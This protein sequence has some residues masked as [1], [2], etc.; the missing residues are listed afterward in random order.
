MIFTSVALTAI[1]AAANPALGHEATLDHGGTSYQVSYE[2]LVQ[3]RTKTVG[4][5]MGTRPSTER[6]RWTIAVQVERRIGQAGKEQPLSRI[7]PAAHEIE[8][9]AIGSCRQAR[10]SIAA[11]Q[12]DRHDD[13]QRYVVNVAAQDRPAVLAEIDAAH[14]LAL[15]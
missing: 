1:L 5:S 6:C 9:E 2:P 3:A 10:Q 13:I 14:A 8:G 15:N 7:L 12:R 11:A 4:T